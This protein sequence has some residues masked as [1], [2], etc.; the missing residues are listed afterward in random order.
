MTDNAI[1]RAIT[2]EVVDLHVFFVD[3][4]SGR[5]SP[6]VFDSRL[7]P[8]LHEQLHYILPGGQLLT[9]DQLLTGLRGAHGTNPDFRIAIR[10]VEVR[11]TPGDTVLATYTE[12]QRGAKASKPSDNARR[13]TALITREAPFVWLHL[14]ETWL[15]EEAR[16]AGSFDF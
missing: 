6:E 5:A 2:A 14:H 1:L 3:W 8:A 16:A 13:S 9:R 12:W 15:P 11:F 10:D 4:F 7:A